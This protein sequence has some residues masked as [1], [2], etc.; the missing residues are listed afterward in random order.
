MSF[1]TLLSIIAIIF[2]ACAL[3]ITYRK[4]AHRIRLELSLT[5]Y[6]DVI[7]GIVNDGG[8]STSIRSIGYFYKASNV[9]WIT[10]KV[11]DHVANIGISFPI[12]VNAR[13]TFEVF[14]S[15]SHRIPRYDKTYGLCVQ[16]D[17][18]R[19]FMYS[20]HLPLIDVI[21]MHV[22]SWISR[23]SGGR[24]APGIKRPRVKVY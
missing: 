12:F 8:I 24:Y 16:L 10:D 17:T 2:S 14:L 18:G 15:T 5:P 22:T 6:N 9:E 23:V 21:S 7:L 20:R 1:T 4:D 3:L 19:I 11:G 13:S